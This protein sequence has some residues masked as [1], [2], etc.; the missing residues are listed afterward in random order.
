MTIFICGLPRTGKTT[1]SKKLKTVLKNFNIIVSEAIRN[2]FQK[3]NSD[4]ARDWGLKNSYARKILFPIYVKEFLEWNEKFS[5]FE[6]IFDCA[7]LSLEQVLPIADKNDI[8]ICF[9]FGCR[10]IN[11]IMEIISNYEHDNDY[12][13]QF[14]FDKLL[15]F[16]GDLEIQDKNNIKF[17]KKNKLLY[18][19]TSIDREKVIDKAISQIVKITEQLN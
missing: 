17:C 13:K 11:E 1:F 7:L 12:T 9:G 14:S 2:G 19:D 3:M 16:W 8:I 15:K 4:S 6:T 10:T 18:F 5:G